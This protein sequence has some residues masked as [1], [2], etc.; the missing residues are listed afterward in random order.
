MPSV[1]VGGNIRANRDQSTAYAGRQEY[2]SYSGVLSINQPLMRLGNH[3]TYEQGV[4]QAELA[5]LQLRQAEQALRLRVS[6]GFFEVLQ[7]EDALRTLAVQK[8]AFATQLAQARRSYEVGLSPITDVSEAQ[9]RY[10][11]TL[12]QEIAARNDLALRQRV[13]EKS[14]A[15]ALP[16]LDEVDPSAAINLL[17][18]SEVQRLRQAAA[19]GSLQ[20]A[21]AEKT[22]AIARIEVERQD[23]AHAPTIDIVGTMAKNRNATYG[24]FG[25]TTTY[26][27]AIGVEFQ[28]PLYQG[29]AVSSRV[30]EAVALLGRAEAELEEARRQAALDADQAALGVE[31]GS[32]LVQALVQAVASTRQQV[33]AT[34][35]GFEVGVRT[36]VDVLN[37]EQQLFT[38]QRDLSAARYQV[39]L[40]ALQ[41]KAAAGSLTDD[42]LR[43]VDR[44]LKAR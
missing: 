8:E 30:R 10:D 3:K 39:L 33:Q 24:P 14:I 38:A 1:T 20:V 22:Q 28:L 13:L 4:L 42:D 18:E 23:A 44:L 26:P 36:R 9:S 35:R 2:G 37:A 5:D 34:R 32:A 11:L 6:R 21:L 25:G 16:P 15:R 19:T 17:S 12:A 27:R 31:S 43:A 40:A 41:L 7:A 29:G